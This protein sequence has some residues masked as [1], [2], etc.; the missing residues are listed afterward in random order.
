MYCFFY[1]FCFSSS[2]FGFLLKAVF[3]EIKIKNQFY[4]IN[5]GF[6]QITDMIIIIIIITARMAMALSSAYYK[7]T[8]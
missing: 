7:Q 5:V 8:R 6:Q 3:I 2:F 1:V 4:V